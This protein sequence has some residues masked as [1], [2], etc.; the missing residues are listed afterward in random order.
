MLRTV[1]AM[2][3]QT[4]AEQVD[5]F[6]VGFEEQIGPQLS[7]IFADEQAALTECGRARERRHRR[8]SHP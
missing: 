7:G 4:I 2:S 3:N 5:V 1:P 8:R 6:N